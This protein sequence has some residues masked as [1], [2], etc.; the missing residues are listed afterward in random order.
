MAD[1]AW[2]P[3]DS[4]RL[5]GLSTWG[6][7]Y[8]RVN[9]SGHVE[10]C[11]RTGRPGQTVDLRNLVQDLQRRGLEL[12]LL[13]RFNG[14]LEDRIEQLFGC[15]QRS[16]TEYGYAGK[17]RGV[18]PIKVNQQRHVV[19]ALLTAGQ[20]HGLGV[21]V[22]S[23]P[24][25][26]AVLALLDDPDALLICNGYKDRA[27]LE[28]ALLATRLGR[29][30]VIVIERFDELREL[31]EVAEETGIAPVIGL[32]AKL[33]TRGAGRWESSSG[34]RSKFG[35]GPRFLVQAVD[36]LKERGRL[37][38]LKLLHFHI[39]SQITSIVNIKKALREGSRL[40]AELSQL[41]APLQYFDVG[42]GLG[43]DYD[44]TRTNALLSIDYS[45]Q[46]YAND[47]V[48]TIQQACDEAGIPHPDLVSESGR[49]LV[50]HHSALVVEV[51]GTSTSADTDTPKAPGPDD[52][53]PLIN[54][55]ESLQSL[56][57][58][59]YREVFHDVTTLKEEV[60]TLFNHGML[61]LTQRAW[62][63]EISRAIQ[64][65]VRDIVAEL[66]EVPE[67]LNVLRRELADIYFCNF[68]I[69]QSLPDTWAIRHQFPLV[70]LQ[71]HQERPTRQAVL[72]DITC[73]SDGKIEQFG[74]DGE[75]RHT[76]PLHPLSS[77]QPYYLAFF[78]VGAYQEIL[79]DLHNLFG[80][81]SAV[82][83]DVDAHGG[84]EIRHVVQGDRVREVLEYVEFRIPELMERI[85][86][87]SEKALKNGKLTFE[88]SARF[89]KLYEE[90]IDGSTYPLASRP[91]TAAKARV[92]GQAG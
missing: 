66:D 48:W 51:S 24:E 18:Y 78:L 50:A 22:G 15:F 61:S 62:A 89:L 27:F 60:L 56:T 45:E 40:F 68:S 10:V 33:S 46:E 14:I 32:R 28:T 9:A 52:P 77:D 87:A 20:S 55:W 84:Y 2:S 38:C 82:H 67:E 76:V 21:E 59:N 11:P 35:L 12:P 57:P 43:V 92:A 83:V 17:Y 13:V 39:G 63:E 81:T 72:A 53:S 75:T 47:V 69:F 16:I 30:P 4:E 49:A 1:S 5:Y 37:D 34:E 23:K 19:Q 70:P 29:N 79:G 65:R 36:L 44:G 26:L 86:D 64:Q 31:L 25:L 3:S 80:D 58:R 88:E 54:L 74:G 7:G 85:R 41:G 73:D 90:G 8:F 42:G 91:E 71:G 6:R